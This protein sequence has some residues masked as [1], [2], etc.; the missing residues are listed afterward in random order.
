MNISTASLDRELAFQIS[1]LERDGA[2]KINPVSSAQCVEYDPMLN[3]LQRIESGSSSDKLI[4][5][6]GYR[7][8]TSFVGRH[9]RGSINV[10]SPCYFSSK[11]N[12]SWKQLVILWETKILRKSIPHGIASGN[13][14]NLWHF[15]NESNHL[16]LN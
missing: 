8:P 9:T 1:A 14:F 10:F 4:Q 15:T 12:T 13:V 2:V 16:K 7:A 3:V 5:K 11:E 6:N